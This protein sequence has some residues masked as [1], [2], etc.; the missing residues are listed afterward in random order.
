MKLE[1]AQ[2]LVVHTFPGGVD[3]LASILGLDANELHR[4]I[5]SNYPDSQLSV[6]DAI[7]IQLTTQDCRILETEAKALNHIVIP[8]SQFGHGASDIDLMQSYA[9][10]HSELGRFAMVFCQALDNTKIKSEF[11]EKLDTQ[12][13]EIFKSVIQLMH[14]IRQYSDKPKTLNKQQKHLLEFQNQLAEILKNHINNPVELRSAEEKQGVEALL[15]LQV[16]NNEEIK[17]TFG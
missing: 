15:R 13:S 9:Q 14:C 1:D 4:Q 17:K 7:D 12:A 16:A 2:N 5:D 11:C 8:L 3:A 10:L 6:T